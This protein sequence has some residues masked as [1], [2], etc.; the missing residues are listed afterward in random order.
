VIFPDTFTV[1]AIDSDTGRPVPDVAL[2][3]ELQAQRKNNYPVGPIITDEFGQARFT[4][5]ACENSID[6]SKRMFLMDYYGDL[7]SC[8]PIATVRLHAPKYIAVM[9][10]NYEAHPEFW[11]IGFEEPEKLFAALRKARNSL[12]DQAH[13]AVRSSEILAHPE[14]KFFLKRKAELDSGG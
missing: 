6:A 2:V 5:R 8:G 13:L 1:T 9:T 14:V 10:E 7:Q 12:Y 11:G 4:R 3:L